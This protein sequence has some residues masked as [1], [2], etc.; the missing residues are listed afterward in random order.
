MFSLTPQER[1]VVLFLVSVA[2]LGIGTNFLLRTNLKV[3][4]LVAVCQDIGKINLNTAD[5]DALMSVT[6]IGAKLTQRI[7]EYRMSHGGFRDMEELKNIK[8]IN[9]N[10]YEKIKDSLCIK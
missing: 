6:G 5:D 2:L 9:G 8:G 10:K 4:S 7:I 3:G 1:Q